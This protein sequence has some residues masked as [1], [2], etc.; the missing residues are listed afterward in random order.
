M[1]NYY[2]PDP[3][4]I[5]KINRESPDSKLYTLQFVDQKI[6]KAFKFTPGQFVMA[7]IIGQGE[8]PFDICSSSYETNTFQ[9]LV[10]KVGS[11]TQ[12]I[13][14]LKAGDRMHIRGPYGHGFPMPK[15]ASKNLLLIGGGCGFVTMR[16]VI[17]DYIKK[18]PEGQKLQVFFGVRGEDNLLFRKEFKTW[19][20]HIDLHIIA[21][22]P[23]AKWPYHKGLITDLFSKVKLL[24]N[25][26]ALSC[27]PPIMYRFCL[28]ELKKIQVPDENIYLSFERRMD[29]GTGVCQHCAMG[30]YYVCKDG[31]VFSYDMI[32][33]IPNV[34]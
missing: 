6:Q 31:P 16:T 5:L 22:E 12:K 28:K 24:K 14:E 30:S 1:K 10:R 27:G 8:A 2:K 15:L 7:G 9:L 25:V 29:C 32:K 18:K 3:A 20:Q 23:P 4:K 11:L 13:H 26:A 21:S 33:D 17:L 34:I 19:S